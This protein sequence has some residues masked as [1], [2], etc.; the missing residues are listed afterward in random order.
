MF[1]FNSRNLHIE[2]IYFLIYEIKF[3]ITLITVNVKYTNLL[4]DRLTKIKIF[5]W[6]SCIQS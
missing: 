1:K 2:Y 3:G 6:F 4:I 5:K